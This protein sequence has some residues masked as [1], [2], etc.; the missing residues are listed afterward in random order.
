MVEEEQLDARNIADYIRHTHRK[1][2]DRYGK[3][4]SQATMATW[5][6][7]S[8]VSSAELR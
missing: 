1:V 6:I 4:R 5:R 3:D 8:P 7:E 2:K